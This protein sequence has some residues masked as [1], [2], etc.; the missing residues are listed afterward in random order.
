MEIKEAVTKGFLG[1]DLWYE[2]PV[3][4]QEMGEKEVKIGERKKLIIKRLMLKA[5]V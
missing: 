5:I 3:L 2:Y 1:G 4:P